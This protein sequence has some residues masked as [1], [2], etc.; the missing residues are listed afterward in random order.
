MIMTGPN[1]QRIIRQCC[2]S[3]DSL[4]FIREPQNPVDVTLSGYDASSAP[5]CL[6]NPD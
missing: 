3:G 6:T 2:R 1:R 4:F 5:T